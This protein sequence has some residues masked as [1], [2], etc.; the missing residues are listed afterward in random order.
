MSRL[1][2][3]LLTTI[4]VI[5]GVLS[6]SH[7]AHAADGTLTFTS[8]ATTIAPGE[9]VILTWESTGAVDLETWGSWPTS[10][11]VD[12]SG[13]VSVQLDY[14][15]TY[16]FGLDG[17]HED[18]DEFIEAEVEIT[19]TGDMVSLDPMRN[20]HRHEPLGH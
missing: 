10:G 4:V 9:S 7:A 1:C 13:S 19:V 14:P 20:L 2:S 12:P 16:F 6:F 18:D 17:F 11:P 5:F 15:G 3:T 8:S